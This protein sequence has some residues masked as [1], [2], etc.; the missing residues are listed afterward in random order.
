MVSLPGHLHA[1][2]ALESTISQKLLLLA[3]FA[4]GNYNEVA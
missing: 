1:Q 4:N 2:C 3:A